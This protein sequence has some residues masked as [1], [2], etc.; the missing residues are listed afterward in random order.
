MQAFENCLREVGNQ[1]HVVCL[2]TQ[3]EV[4]PEDPAFRHPT[5]PV[6]YFYTEEEEAQNI[7]KEL[8]WTMREDAG[9]G[10]R[11]VV[12]SPEPRH[13]VDI[14][15]IEALAKRGAVVIAGGGGGFPWSAGPRR[16]AAGSRR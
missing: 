2:L 7:A 3:V 9:R 11:L 5:K 12:A 10:W 6:G 13:V 16:S 1:R 8:G 14:S 4:D 15:L